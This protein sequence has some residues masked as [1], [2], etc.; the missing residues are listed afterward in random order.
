MYEDL[1]RAPK[2]GDKISFNNGQGSPPV[3]GEVVCFLA[4]GAKLAVLTD[5]DLP[6]QAFIKPNQV[7]SIDTPEYVL[8]VPE[9][10]SLR[11][12]AERH[13]GPAD[14]PEPE[15]TPYL[16]LLLAAGTIKNDFNEVIR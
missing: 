14:L 8:S 3:R 12:F 15:V 13:L 7:L 2:I 16:L 4:G 11:A 10:E 5:A 6:Y 1:K 9:I